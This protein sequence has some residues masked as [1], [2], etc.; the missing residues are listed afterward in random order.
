MLIRHESTWHVLQPCSSPFSVKINIDDCADNDLRQKMKKKKKLPPNMVFKFHI[1]QHILP[2]HSI[3]SSC[4]SKVTMQIKEIQKSNITR[5][6]P[7]VFIYG[8]RY[9]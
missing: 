8:R 4:Y 5:M 6:C 7:R 1:A 9:K 3:Q 2:K